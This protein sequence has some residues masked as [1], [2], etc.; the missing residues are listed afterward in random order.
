MSRSTPTPTRRLAA[1]CAALLLLCVV[2]QPTVAEAPLSLQ[3]CIDLALERNLAHRR[4]QQALEGA[5]TYLQEAQAPFGFRADANLTIPS[6]TEVSDTFESEAVET[7][8]RSEDT[9]FR[10]A[11]NLQLARRVPH[12]GRFT[13]SSSA[14][15]RDFTSNRREDF[16][17]YNGDVVFGYNHD[18][19]TRP[20]EETSLRQARLSL[21]NA[22]SSFQRQRLEIQAGAIDRYYD[23]VQTLRRLEIETQ[24]LSQSR[25]SMDLAQRKFE[26]GLI[27]EVQALRLKFALL[28]AEAGYAEAETD[29]ERSRDR[30]RQYIGL[31][32]GSPLEVVTEVEY[33]QYPVDEA[34]ALQVGLE[35]RTDMREAEITEQI[36]ELGLEATRDRLGPTAA[37]DARVRLGGLGP[38]IGD[39]R[40][41][42]ERKL[43]SVAIQ[44]RVPLIDSG[45]RRGQ[46]SRAR[47]DLE[48]S[49]LDRALIHQG[50]VLEIKDAVRNLEQA[51]RQIEWRNLGLKVAERAYDVEQSRFEL[52]LAKS[53][54]LLDAQTDLTGARINALSAIINYQRRL[55][56]LR[57]ASMSDVA[58][59]GPGSD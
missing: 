51:E 15:R 22:R 47:V 32:S 4:N 20:W 35:Q 19:L 13:I 7:R 38:E 2:A 49:R 42:F 11:G 46:I 25:A 27:P 57:L 29:I 34:R 30:L 21:S 43:W 48:Q 3:D 39:V 24:R 55:K 14:E 10:Y 16:S 26:I 17:D 36:R 53:Q 40:D 56:D 44:L 50:I 33:Q 18:I 54:E 6:Y 52:G 28:E 58:E 41:N 59:L 1:C 5:A 8:F 31:E 23:L 37:L 9:D 12:L 45:S